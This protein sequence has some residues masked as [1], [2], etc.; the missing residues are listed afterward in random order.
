MPRIKIKISLTLTS[1]PTSAHTFLSTPGDVQPDISAGERE[2]KPK[3]TSKQADSKKECNTNS[4]I[5]TIFGAGF[6]VSIA[7]FHT[8]C[9]RPDCHETNLMRKSVS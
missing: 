4:R 8:L 2:A 1:K 3:E 7:R 6:C 5:F 9:G